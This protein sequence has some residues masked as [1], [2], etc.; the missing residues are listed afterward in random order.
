MTQ[1]L[2]SEI[3]RPLEGLVSVDTRARI[4]PTPE[5][6]TADNGVGWRAWLNSGAESRMVRLIEDGGEAV[7]VPTLASQPCADRYQIA[8]FYE[9]EGWVARSALLPMNAREAVLRNA[10]GSGAIIQPGLVPRLFDDGTMAVGP[11]EFSASVSVEELGFSV[12]V[13]RHPTSFE[14]YFGEGWR[15]LSG[16]PEGLSWKCQGA[17]SST[18][19]GIASRSDPCVRRLREEAER[20][21]TKG[22]FVARVGEELVLSRECERGDCRRHGVLSRHLLESFGREQGEMRHIALQSACYQ[23]VATV[24]KLPHYPQEGIGYGRLGGKSQPC[25]AVARGTSLEW[26]DGTGAGEIVWSI[27]IPAHMTQSEPRTCSPKL[28]DLAT[29]PICIPTQDL[30]EITCSGPRAW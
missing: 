13:E 26:E 9:L 8:S 15:D 6:S 18:G 29:A 12:P 1:A 22:D 2:E 27:E 20:G 14:E 28:V 4:A 21:L 3:A 24:D 10:D 23:V 11:S 17:A 5:A 25:F 19:L 30:R 16:E 7:R